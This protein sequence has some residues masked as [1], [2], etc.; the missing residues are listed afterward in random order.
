M[1][2]VAGKTIQEVKDQLNQIEELAAAGYLCGIGGDSLTEVRKMANRLDLPI[3]YAPDP[4]EEEQCECE[5]HCHD[6]PDVDI[7]RR[8][9]ETE[10]AYLDRICQLLRDM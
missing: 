6:D 3:Q 2:I 7:T 5:C 8:L 4:E 10:Q 9:N 1:I